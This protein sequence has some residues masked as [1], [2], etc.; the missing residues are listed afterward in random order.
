MFLFFA[1]IYFLSWRLV[2]KLELPFALAVAEVNRGIFAIV[3]L[4]NG[5]QPLLH[6]LLI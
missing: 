6:R 2:G 3:W 5:T 4:G 1:D